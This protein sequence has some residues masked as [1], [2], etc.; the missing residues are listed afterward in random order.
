MGLGTES[1]SVI[2]FRQYFLST[3]ATSARKALVPGIQ[4]VGEAGILLVF[5]GG[6][7]VELGHRLED[8]AR[9]PSLCI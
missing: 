5:G 9:I 7:G 3:M 1:F 2:L 8:R 4:R 6:D